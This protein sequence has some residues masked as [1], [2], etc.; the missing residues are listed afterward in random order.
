M[1]EVTVSTTFDSS[2]YYTGYKGRDAN[3]HGHTWKVEVTFQ[4][5]ELDSMGMVANPR[6]LMR[7]VNRLVSTFDHMRMNDIEPFDKLNPTPERISRFIYEGVEEH[8]RSQERLSVKSVSVQEGCRGVKA[9]FS[10]SQKG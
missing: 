5:K 9:T 8:L 6:D 2:H 1:Y 3:I 4:A 7:V 10:W